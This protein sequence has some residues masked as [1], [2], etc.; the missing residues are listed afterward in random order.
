MA[1]VCKNYLFDTDWVWNSNTSSIL[2]RIITIMYQRWCT[3]ATAATATTTTA[4]TTAAAAATNAVTARSPRSRHPSIQI[5]Q[6]VP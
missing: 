2:F 5:P 4:T 6:E 3:T 1:E